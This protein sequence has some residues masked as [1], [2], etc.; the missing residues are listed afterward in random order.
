MRDNHR[1]RQFSAFMRSRGLFQIITGPTHDS[2]RVIDL[3]WVRQGSGSVYPQHE[4]GYFSD[5]NYNYNYVYIHS[6]VPTNS[7]QRLAIR[8][9]TLYLF[10]IGTVMKHKKTS[11]T[12]I[13]EAIR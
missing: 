5:L 2:G 12:S 11:V 3:L 1:S 7:K 8:L 13:Q 9:F 4:C 10:E 6:I